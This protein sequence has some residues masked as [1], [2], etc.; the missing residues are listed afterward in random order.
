VLGTVARILLVDDDP[1]FCGAAAAALRF[2][3]HDVVEAHHGGE[4]MAAMDAE[5]AVLIVTDLVMPES[6]GVGLIMLVRKKF[7]DVK[8]IAITGGKHPEVYLKIAT[9]LGAGAALAKPFTLEE[10]LRTVDRVLGGK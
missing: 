6:E 5:P 9:M 4:A 8:V 10:L 7:P 2:A 1:V 3:G